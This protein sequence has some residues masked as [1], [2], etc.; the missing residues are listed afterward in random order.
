MSKPMPEVNIHASCVALGARGILLL[1]KSGAGKSDLALRL[2]DDGARL[3]ADD[4][5]ILFVANGALHAKAP[6]SIKGLLEIRGLGI[7]TVPARSKVE[8]ALVVLLGREGARLPAP[9]VYHMPAP[10]KGAKP[11]PQIVLDARFASTPAKVRAALA[12]FSRGLFRDTF[13]TK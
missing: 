7:V 6:D 13:I 9:R 8:V 12:A 3:V 11:V 4:R 10:L 5:T 1:G 2:T